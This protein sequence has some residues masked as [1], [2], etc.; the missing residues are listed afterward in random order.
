MEANKEIGRAEAVE[1]GA[2]ASATHGD[3]ALPLELDVRGAEQVLLLLKILLV[4]IFM[5]GFG[6]RA[7]RVL[8]VSFPDSGTET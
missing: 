7:K 2:A 1:S 4:C 5:Q 3:G 6:G 8:G